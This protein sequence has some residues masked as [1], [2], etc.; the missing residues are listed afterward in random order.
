MKKLSITLLCL[1]A[2]F[3]LQA[4]GEVYDLWDGTSS[5]PAISGNTYTI[6]SASELAWIA[7]QNDSQNGFYGKTIVLT[8]NIDING[9]AYI[10]RPIGSAAVTFRGTLSGGNHLVRGLRNIQGNDG[11][12]LFG[13]IGA[14]G[15][16][17]NLGISGG[18]LLAEGQ[19]RV[20]TIAGVCAGEI[21]KC[22]SMAEIVVSGNITGGLVGDLRAGGKLTD[23]YCS[24]LIVLSGDTMGVIAGQNAGSIRRAYSIGYAKNGTGFVGIDNNGSY[25]DCYY[26]RKL[27]YQE[28]G[29]PNKG[30]T[31]KDVSSEMYA[32]MR[33]KSN[34]TTTADKYPQL[35]GFVGTD[36]SLLSV[37]PVILDTVT[38]TDINHANG[39]FR[40]FK[41]YNSDGISWACQE[42]SGEQWINF[43]SLYP[44]SVEVTRPCTETDV[45]ADAQLGTESRAVYFR[46]ERVKDLKPGRFATKTKQGQP[47]SAQ[48][49]WEEEVDIK[50]SVSMTLATDGWENKFYTVVLYGYNAGGDTIVI[51]TV[52]TE[53]TEAEY[54]SWFSTAAVRTDTAGTF[55]MRSFVHDDGCVKD[56]MP[57]SGSFEYIVYPKFEKG[58]IQSGKDTIYLNTIPYT[59]NI[60]SITAASG[61]DGQIS[62][63]WQLNNSNISSQTDAALV[64]YNISKKG[65]YT[66]TRIAKDGKCSK[67]QSE[68]EYTF[69]VFD[70]FNPGTVSK[71]GGKNDKTFCSLS[72]AQAYTVKATAA[73]GGT[74]TYNY[75]W[76]FSTNGGAKVLISGATSQNLPLS[77]VNIAAGNTY[78]FY[79]YAED[80][81]RFTTMT[82]SVDSFVVKVSAPFNKGSIQNVTDTVYLSK[83]SV[84]VNVASVAAATGGD[85]N[86]SYSW[87]VDGTAISGATNA[88][89][90][91]YTITSSGVYVFTR[92]DKDGECFSE[93]ADGTYTVVVYDAFDPGYLIIDQASLTFCTVNDAKSHTIS[94]S[95]PT[96]GSG[97]YTYQW[98]TMSG[99]TATPISGATAKD[100]SLSSV[101]LSAGN[102]YT[103]VRSAQDNTSHTTLIRSQFSQQIY[104]MKELNAG[105]IPDEKRQKECFDISED[106]ITITIKETASASGDG[107]LQYRWIMT[108]QHGYSSEVGSSANLSYKIDKEIAVSSSPITVVREVRQGDCDWVRSDG[109]VILTYD[110]RG[111][112]T[113]QLTVC[114]E[115]KPYTLTW[116]DS[117]GNAFSHKFTADGESHTFT[118]D[119]APSGC[120]SDTV[121]TIHFVDIPVVYT[122]ATAD[123]CQSNGTIIFSFEAGE[124]ADV[125]HVTY[126]PDLAKYMGRSDSIGAITNAGT[127]IIRNV[128]MIGEGDCYL[129]V[130]LGNS[131]G[132]LTNAA[133][134]CFSTASRIDFTVSISGYVHSKFSKVLF[135]DNNPDNGELPDPK[136]HFTGYQWYKNG[137]AVDGATDQYYHENGVYL[138]G[139]YY[140]MMKADNGNTYRSCSVLMPEED[141]YNAPASRVY[142]IPVAS[143]ESVTIKATDGRAEIFNSTGECV[144]QIQNIDTQATVSAP[145]QAGLYY[146]KIT[147]GDGSVNTEK[148]IVR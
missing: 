147:D 19:R 22:W 142:P 109:E 70:A 64:N 3:R 23:V 81:T 27:Y 139:T 76:R 54:L 105:K 2:V 96:G 67:E 1:L 43:T 77:S 97:K 72:D 73:T 134:I 4:A 69:V 6:T 79:R 66:F 28:P 113:R 141:Y 9:A 35:T 106:N 16:V 56:W 48:I 83:G 68:G 87:S 65:T 47:R 145:R 117:N 144:M 51:D 30:I 130:Q 36:A 126:S 59:A 143:G 123:L 94:G 119:Y 85:G 17:E 80:N 136:L 37:A 25:N 71:D 74:G 127:I 52:R 131:G 14:D 118:D 75:E 45:I 31:A 34:W 15:K 78:T 38:T 128:P 41:V 129:F 13:H 46:P 58:E 55:F 57:N 86:I 93:Q 10:W 116:Y 111:Y 82:Q 133:N 20:G 114:V 90:S 125:F 103:F 21:S 99:S 61:G 11:I 62:Y 7:E 140:V 49:C 33:G 18:K 50:D 40:N 112:G 100:L 135:V 84:T 98:Y 132:D 53:C 137:I 107:K 29:A 115:E 44:D 110:W 104:I 146:V 92:Q 124:D 8:V 122:D 42:L 5:S 32:I 138:Y 89:L 108:D 101:S 63:S 148:L 24:G 26:D 102:T 39:L 120:P 95:T 91:S 12:G 60:S 88:A 121:Y